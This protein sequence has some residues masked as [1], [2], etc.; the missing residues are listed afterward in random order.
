MKQ[1]LFA[2]GLLFFLNSQNLCAQASIFAENC[3]GGSANDLGYSILPHTDGNYIVAGTTDSDDG[4]ISVSNG[5]QDAWLAMV[6]S[7]GILLWED[8][9]G[10]SLNDYVKDMVAAPD[11]SGYVIAGSTFSTDGDVAGN[12]GQ[13]DAWVFKVNND[14]DLLWQHCYG[15]DTVELLNSIIST[16]DGGYLC[17]GNA[18]SNNGDLTGNN[19]STDFWAIKLGADGTLEWQK[20]YGGSAGDFGFHALEHADGYVFVGYTYSSD[21]DVTSHY[22][23]VTT[24]DYWIVKTDLDGNI[25]WQRSAGGTATD[26]ATQVIQTPTGNYLVA[27]N[28]FSNDGDVSGHYSTTAYT[29]IWLLEIDPDGNLVTDKNIG[30]SFDDEVNKLI[31]DLDGNYLLCGNSES[32]DEDFT[33]HFGSTSSPD[34]VVLQVAGDYSV[35]WSKNYGGINDDLGRSIYPYAE[36]YYQAIGYTK[37]ISGDIGFHHGT[38][39]NHDFWI[40]NLVICAPEIV[41]EPVDV[42]SCTGS[43]LTLTAETNTGD[44]FYTWYF[45][46]TEVSTTSASLTITALTGA[47]A[48]SYYYIVQGACGADTSATATITLSAFET[49]VIMPEI[50]G[51]FC[52]T[53]PFTASASTTGSGYTYQWYLND[54]PIT[55]A[56]GDTY[57]I[58]EPGDYTVEISAGGC[59]SVSEPLSVSASLTSV[60]VSIDGSTNL[61]GNGTVTFSAP[62]GYAYQWFK[63]DAAISGATTFTYTATEPGV[64][65][66]E[67]TYGFCNVTSVDIAVTDSAPESLISAAGNLDIC[68]TGSVVLN[69]ASSGTGYAFQWL[70]NDTPIAGATGTS[71]TAADTGYYALVL[72][73]VSGCSDTSETLHVINTCVSILDNTVMN[74]INIYPNPSNGS[75]TLSIIDNSQTG[76]YT[77]SVFNTIGEQIY[78]E[79]GEYVAANK[80]KP[81]NLQNLKP[82]TYMLSISSESIYTF[83][84]LLIIQ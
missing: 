77:L 82:G 9:V 37:S 83:K 81:I 41:T 11:G 45:T 22:G 5:Q 64:Y 47:Y 70:F 17:L 79:T 6:D 20:N 57:L 52:E 33:E 34:F 75:F 35:N 12:N 40:L 74:G 36:G 66:V 3:I 10:G 15:G 49:A 51:D 29:D 50:A 4:D 13:R 53:G 21:G 67:V 84:Q 80:T 23:D 55:G 8:A 18:T 14:G 65:R 24:S 30:G 26:Y 43:S 68:E 73:T 78:S 39:S 59:S 2:A 44:Y 27:G 61:C 46:G 54:L 63:D 19:G 56:D 38:S 32:G 42:E 72:T 60:T 25:T 62:S 31:Y 1:T 48:G 28:A 16:T 58:I 76:R 69:N 71:Y 7:G